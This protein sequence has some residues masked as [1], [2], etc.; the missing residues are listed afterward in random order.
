MN[1]E[2]KQCEFYRYP[3]MDAY[4]EEHCVNPKVIQP[5]FNQVNGLCW[6]HESCRGARTEGG[7][8]EN[9]QH[10]EKKISVWKRLTRVFN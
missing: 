6:S 7:R 3:N 10:Y 2:C 4:S 5:Y 1:P 9:G 8:C